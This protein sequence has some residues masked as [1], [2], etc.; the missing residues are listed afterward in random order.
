M[1]LF[2]SLPHDVLS[3]V[4][5]HA[6]LD[7]WLALRE[8]CRHARSIVPDWL[9]GEEPAGT[10]APC[11]IADMAVRRGDKDMLSRISRN[12]SPE[13][14]AR[15]V[16]PDLIMELCTKSRFDLLLIAH[17]IGGA[18]VCDWEMEVAAFCGR[19]DFMA[20]ARE[21]GCPWNQGTCNA[22]IMGKRFETLKWARAQ[23]C[24]WDAET[25][26]AFAAKFGCLDTLRWAREQ[27]CPWCE[28]T[29]E[30]AAREGHLDV[31]QWALDNGC[32]C[33]ARICFK[34]AA[35]RP[36]VRDFLVSRFR[37]LA[38]H[39]GDPPNSPSHDL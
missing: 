32:P 24:P 34:A 8:T 35:F 25:T 33:D 1:S 38:H 10:P 3:L 18:P 14:R 21:R 17:E 31:L 13:R 6:G 28:F 2:V 15:L 23:G 39:H 16:S 20:W 5:A 37:W 9:S 7:A 11:W 30:C 22:A 36:Q 29:A 26:C 4:A 19:T 12:V 27:G